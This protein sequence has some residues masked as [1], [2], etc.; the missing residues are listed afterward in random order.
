MLFGATIKQCLYVS[1]MWVGFKLRKY[2]TKES[3][4]KCPSFP[5]IPQQ[6]LENQTETLLNVYKQSYSVQR[7]LNLIAN[8][9]NTSLILQRASLL[10]F[11]FWLLRSCNRS[12][13][14]VLHRQTRHHI[15][16]KLEIFFHPHPNMIKALMVSFFNLKYKIGDKRQG[17]MCIV[18]K[19]FIWI[20]CFA[21]L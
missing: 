17:Y 7:L 21:N 6:P 13:P 10:A 11:T 2:F 20:Q 19:G 3:K 1:L 9:H 5:L 14:P 8:M 15:L 18:I 4:V 16:K 12:C